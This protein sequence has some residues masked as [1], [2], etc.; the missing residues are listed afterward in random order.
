MATWILGDIHGCADELHELLT[1][2]DL[3]PEDC[4]VS[5]GDLFHRGPAPLEVA[6]L[7]RAAG[8]H[9]VLGNHEHRLLARHGLAP[10]G[11]PN[12]E[13]RA[14]LPTR[15]AGTRGYSPSEPGAPG[16]R[17]TPVDPLDL[18]GD[19]GAACLV[20]PAQGSRILEFLEGHSGY[21]LTDGELSGAGPTPD[22]RPWVVVH[23]GRDPRMELAATPRETLMYARR[24]GGR[25]S[26][27]W[28][29][30]YDGPELVLFGHTPAKRPRSRF[31]R[32][33]LVALGLDTGCV[34][35]GS[36]SAYSPE[37][38]ALEVVPAQRCYAR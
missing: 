18:K 12:P 1:R 23:A 31:A 35:G 33:R 30:R 16:S 3:G 6:D 9:F 5:C 7:M 17:P 27:W 24:L 29:E 20:E 25:A 14:A 15:G 28:Y 36:L 19:G 38:D 8:G 4:L 13:P 37:L 32:G 34:Y 21:Y 22:G 10:R 26:P 2:L 11:G